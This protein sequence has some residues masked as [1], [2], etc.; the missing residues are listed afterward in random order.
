MNLWIVTIGSSDIQLH[1]DATNK[2]QG[3]SQGEMSHEIWSYWYEDGIKNEHC[4]S[5]VFEPK[6][7]FEDKDENYRIASRVL[8]TVYELS[9]E[10]TR[11]EIFDY[12]TFPLLSKFIERL[13]SIDVPNK[14]ALLLTDQ[15]QIFSSEEQ[16]QDIKSPYWD[17]T[18]KLEP[19][20][21][22]YFEKEFP[23][24]E[25]ELMTLKLTPDEQ[26]GLDDWNEVLTLVQKEFIKLDIPKD[27]TLYVSHQ[28]GTPAISSA[29]QF[30]SLARFRNNVQFL[31]SNEYSQKT[32]T[33]PKSTYLGAIQRQEAI[34][35]LKR[36]DYAAVQSFLKDY[37]D[38]ETQ[39]LLNAAIK[40]NYA[41][42]DE[43]ATEIHNLSDETFIQQV[44]E[45]SQQWWWTAYE[46]AYLAIIRLEQGNTVEAFFHA[47]RAVEGAFLEWGKEEFKSHI[48]IHNDRAYLQPSIL[49]DPKNYFKKAKIKDKENPK[50]NNSLG[51]L[52]LKFEELD[53]KL[54]NQQ[55]NE[56]KPKGELLYGTTLY[57]LF[58]TQKPDFKNM[59]EYKRF[60]AGDG[61]G[62][63]RNKNFHQLQGLT[64]QDVYRDWEVEN[65][66]E[67][68]Q[69]ILTYLNFITNDDPQKPEFT[70]LEEASLMAQVHQELE[71]AIAS[72]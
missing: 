55:E 47:F 12:L 35:L 45:R 32:K 14:I 52:K 68:E 24:V 63:K 13:Q 61:I 26:P 9:D 56:Q 62:E 10:D 6:R 29:V 42:F 5:V 53:E 64:E 21:K 49:K 1:S 70:S 58:E 2:Q 57:R 18:C 23:D 51:N 54:K 28:A 69:R 66:E 65:L 39:I 19:I 11:T 40:W 8:G 36:H 50:K 43:F 4:Y 33:I 38:S 41:K 60:L 72:K 3:R 44:N 17:D 15:S 37:L 71:K 48:E 34:A 25:L 31:V 7:A 20:L 67:W 30:M 27:A 59:A 46:A 22:R 16:R